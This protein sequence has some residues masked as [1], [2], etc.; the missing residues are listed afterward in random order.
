M[1]ESASLIASHRYKVREVEL[2]EPLRWLALGWRDFTRA[3]VPGLVHGLALTLFGAV[4]LAVAREHFWFLAGAFSGFLL[5]GPLAVTGLY[6]VS[7]ALERSEP[8]TLATALRSWIPQD[9]RLVVFGVMLSAAGTVWVLT[10]AS[11][12]TTLAAGHVKTPLDFIR[13]VVIS[14]HSW[15]FELWLALGGAMAAPVY[16]SSVVSIPL[17]LDR[18]IGVWGAVLTSWRCVLANPAP[19]ALWGAMLMA[20]AGVGL[21]TGV[22]LVLVAPWLAHASWHAYRALIAPP[23]D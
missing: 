1:P 10:S 19:L 14:E 9:H 5:M 20:L 2:D 22:G 21:A 15:L 11:L 4:L 7:R 8:A 13:M 6:A 18:S 12:I 17:L 16:A 3:P 23:E